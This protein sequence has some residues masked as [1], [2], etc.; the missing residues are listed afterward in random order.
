MTITTIAKRAFA[1]R[2][3]CVLSRTHENTRCR[4][5]FTESLRDRRHAGFSLLELLIVCA[6]I[7]I[8]AVLALAQYSGR[9]I[10]SRLAS[11]VAQRLRE[12]RA[13][14]VR[15]NALTEST[16]LENYI[17]P[18]IAINFAS[19]PTTA[20]LVVEGPTHTTFSNDIP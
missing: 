10:S 20:T 6:I 2:L 4:Q 16:Q 1:R 15:L 11:V 3:N 9:D 7:S 5:P 17:Q 14:A 18:A 13:S 19:L 12:R 8:V